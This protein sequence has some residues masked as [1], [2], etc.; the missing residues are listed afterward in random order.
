MEMDRMYDSVNLLLSL[1]SENGRLSTWE[2]ATAHEWLEVLNPTEFFQDIVI[3]HEYLE[4]TAST[5][6]TLAVFMKLYPGYQK[7]EIEAFIAKAVCY[8]ENQQML[9]GSWYGC[10]GICFIY[11][12]WFALRG[13]AAAGK[14]CN[15]SL[16]VRK[17]SEF[18]LSTQLASGG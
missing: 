11:G 15:N 13:L 5:I 3:E 7:K 9:D 1:Q 8:L 12:T 17:V 18:L 10:W 16:T 4:S 2:P 14:N 6:Q